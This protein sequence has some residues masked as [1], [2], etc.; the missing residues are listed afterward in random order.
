MINDFLVAKTAFIV[1]YFDVVR[2]ID[3]HGVN[4]SLRLQ[5]SNYAT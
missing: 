5:L 2:A 4:V 3:A 1:K